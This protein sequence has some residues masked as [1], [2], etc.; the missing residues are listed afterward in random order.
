LGWEKK[1]KDKQKSQNVLQKLANYRNNTKKRNRKRRLHNYRALLNI[2]NIK[3]I[4]IT[5]NAREAKTA[6]RHSAKVTQ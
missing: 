6:L 5:V 3:A 1:K 4:H 2:Q